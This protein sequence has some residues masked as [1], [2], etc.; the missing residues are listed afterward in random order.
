VIEAIL[1]GL[2]GLI[3][4]SFLNVCVYRMPR[5][6][7][8]AS[9]ARSFCPE[10]E[11]TIAWY[12][13]LPLLSY[14]LLGGRCRHCSTRIP[15]RY[16][17][18]EFVTGALFLAIVLWLGPTLEAAKYCV[19]AAI[20][21]ALIAMDM[22]ERILADEFTKGGIV[23]ALIFAAFVPM[24]MGLLQ[25]FLPPEWPPRVVSVLEAGFSAAFLSGVLWAIGVA[26]EKLRGKEGL[27]FGD[28]KMVG[29]I[30]AFLG[31]GPALLTVVVG[32]T[33]GSI[34]GLLFIFLTKK[35]ASTYELPFGSFLGLAALIVAF[36]GRSVA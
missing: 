17:I 21:V 36:W 14:A 19:F 34:T 11:K 10:C 16:P 31:L 2:F 3:I 9:P 30:A 7:S 32:S 35:D 28:V 8:V 26:Y 5:D 18:V 25:L 22:E 13:N 27:G 29:M 12:D 15:I 23:A 33:L 4:G 6:L 1:A 24:H 20:Q